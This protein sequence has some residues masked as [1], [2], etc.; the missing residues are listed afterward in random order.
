MSNMAYLVHQIIGS[1]RALDEV[2]VEL[3][4]EEQNA[5]NMLYYNIGLAPITY[6]ID[7]DALEDFGSMFGFGDDGT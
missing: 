7:E 1:A 5:Q 2:H 3:T 4:S 6:G